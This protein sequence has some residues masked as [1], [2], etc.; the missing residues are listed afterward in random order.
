MEYTKLLEGQGLSE[1][2]IKSIVKAMWKNRIFITHEEHLEE[3][4]QKMRLQRNLLKK[5]LELAEKAVK[6]AQRIMET[7]E[8]IGQIRSYYEGKMNSLKQEYEEKIIRTR[9][10]E[11]IRTSLGNTRYPELLAAK[12]DKSKVTFDMDG[13]LTGIEEQ[14]IALQREYKEFFSGPDSSGREKENPGTCFNLILQTDLPIKTARGT[15]I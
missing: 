12:V 11:A 8:D 4:Y 7:Q 6:N 2:Q 9:I 13:N 15:S 14:L 10:D 3:R 5:K 1:E